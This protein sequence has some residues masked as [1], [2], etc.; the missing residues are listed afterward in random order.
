MPRLETNGSQLV[1]IN[2]VEINS[3]SAFHWLVHVKINCKALQCQTKCKPREE[4]LIIILIV[5]IIKKQKLLVD[6]IDF[7]ALIKTRS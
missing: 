6:F 1:E 4:K 2:S 3:V 7:F 5:L